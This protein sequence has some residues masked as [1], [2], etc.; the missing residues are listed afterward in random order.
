MSE[1]LTRSVPYRGAPMT[2][3]SLESALRVERGRQA[4]Q[5]ATLDA[6]RSKNAE[7]STALAHEM[8][9]LEALSA[10]MSGP[11]PAE[12]VVGWLRRTFSFLPGVGEAE[13]AATSVEA[14]LRSQFEA[15]QVRLAEA[16]AF[17]DRLEAAE[18]ELYDEVD[19]LNTR[20]VEAA[21]NE[22]VAAEHLLAVE[23]HQAA[24]RAQLRAPGL[25]E[26]SQRRVEAELDRCR[27]VLAEHAT[28]L[29]LY[30][31]AEERLGRLKESTGRLAETVA[32]LRSDISRY[33]TAAGEKLDLVSG[34]INAVGVAADATA[35]MVELK[36]ALEGM[37]ASLNEATRFVSRTQRYFRENIDGLIDDLDVY[38]DETRQV[39]EENLAY[40]EAADELQIGEA[41][42]QARKRRL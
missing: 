23:G 28:R 21:E 33:V 16:A 41:V 11:E 40:A 27:R 20:I 29:K 24:L 1:V 26:A 6:L 17:T 35:V 2:V 38:D 37:S 7:V 10:Q 3:S 31:T 25:D 14:L 42:A 9:A 30:D 8:T 22:V 5:V 15:S 19:R 39:L 32:H 4:E 12:G 36:H 18:R 13:V 34:Q